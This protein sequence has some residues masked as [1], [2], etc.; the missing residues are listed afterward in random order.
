MDEPHA[1]ARLSGQVTLLTRLLLLQMALLMVLAARVL[2]GEEAA[3][4]AFGLVL[5]TFFVRTFAW[6]VK[7]SR[8]PLQPKSDSAAG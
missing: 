1:L 4:W 5:L 2:F 7:G 8:M 6:M 3:A